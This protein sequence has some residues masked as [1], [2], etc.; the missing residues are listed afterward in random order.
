[1]PGLIVRHVEAVE[2]LEQ[3][4]QQFGK[5]A[6]WSHEAAGKMWIFCCI[7]AYLCQGRGIHV[8]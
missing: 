5:A 2:V 3:F 8:T 4:R 1:V 6:L 7:A